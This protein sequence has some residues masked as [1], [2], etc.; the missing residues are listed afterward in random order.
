MFRLFRAICSL[1]ILFSA[2]DGYEEPKN[3]AESCKFK[4]LINVI[5]DSY[6]TLLINRYKH[7][8]DILPKIYK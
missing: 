6:I 4:K 5:L 3:V 7:N 8:G 1:N 2:E